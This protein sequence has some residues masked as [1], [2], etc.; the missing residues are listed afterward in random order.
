MAGAP[1]DPMCPKERPGDE[2]PLH[3]T[4]QNC[5]CSCCCGCCARNCQRRCW[6]IFLAKRATH[7]T[8][9]GEQ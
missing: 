5:D 6:H 4:Q 3:A 7:R 8:S 2:L 1:P 9:A